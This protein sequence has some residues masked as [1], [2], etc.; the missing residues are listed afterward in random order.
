MYG[1]D[2]QDGTWSDL[3][4]LERPFATD[5]LSENLFLFLEIHSNS[6]S[7]LAT[8]REASVPFFSSYQHVSYLLPL[9]NIFEALLNYLWITWKITLNPFPSESKSLSCSSF[10]RKTIWHSSHRHR[11]QTNVSPFCDCQIC[12]RCKN[13]EYYLDQLKETNESAKYI[14]WFL[15]TLGEYIFFSGAFFGPQ[16]KCLVWAIGWVCGFMHSWV[17]NHP[18][19][20]N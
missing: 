7:T 14:Q 13:F 20:K 16:T 15:L 9:W 1:W 3:Y 10:L 6:R 11:D 8:G 4:F 19:H 17:L 5:I 18:Q 2:R 12:H